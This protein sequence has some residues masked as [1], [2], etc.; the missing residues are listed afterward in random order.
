[1]PSG[2]HGCNDQRTGVVMTTK[3]SI[4]IVEDEFFIAHDMRKVL[5]KYGYGNITISS[6]GEECLRIVAGEKPD[7]ILMDI[8]LG[9][10]MDG[11]ETSQFIMKDY[12]IPVIFLTAHSDESTLQKA[13]HTAPYGYIVKPINKREL[14]SS[15]E[16]ALFKHNIDL[17]LKES[18]QKYRILFEQSRD[19]ICIV[20]QSGYIADVNKAVEDLFRFDK[21]DISGMSVSVLFQ[22]PAVY[23]DMMRHIE[24]EGFV[25]DY[26][27]VMITKDMI[28]RECQITASKYILDFEQKQWCQM[29]IRDITDKKQTLGELMKSRQELSNLSDHLQ[30]LR[31]EERKNIAREIHDVLG[32]YLTAMKIDFIK[33]MK[34]LNPQKKE[35]L[36][37]KDTILNLMDCA[38]DAVSK[39]STELRPG[40]IDDLGLCAACEWQVKE[41]EKRTGII[42][43]FESEPP[44]FDMETKNALAMFRIFQESLTNI[45]RHSGATQVMISLTADDNN[46]LLSVKDNGVG[47]SVDDVENV[48]SYGIIGMRER[49][50]HCGGE[51]RIT[52]NGERGTVVMVRI[53][54]H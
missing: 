51:T 11:I 7:L 44:D 46:V 1:M 23:N 25:I 35:I 48:C 42:C 28:A 33:I 10:G 20:S 30:M 37:R 47:I 41:F 29:I 21:E 43:M 32:Q 5:E 3:P 39:I 54:L 50:L 40:I 12:H 19:P 34:M 24:S 9:S 16:M 2:F 14:Y 38:S 4:L 53:P 36:D 26:D 17:K 52:N 6:S 18:E 15:I 22:E 27:A 8:K 49:A 45:V 13:K 31:E